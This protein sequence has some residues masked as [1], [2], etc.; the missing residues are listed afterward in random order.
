[1]TTINHKEETEE[2]IIK[3][4]PMLSDHS[5]M[6]ANR[7]GLLFNRRSNPSTLKR[8]GLVCGFLS[9]VGNSHLKD[10]L[11]TVIQKGFLGVE[12]IFDSVLTNKSGAPIT[13]DS[14]T[15]FMARLGTSNKPMEGRIPMKAKLVALYRTDMFTKKDFYF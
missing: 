10:H 4:Y 3:K 5:D 1:M 12:P 6:I 13:R 9:S 7:L 2:K 14:E 11:E 15:R 8:N